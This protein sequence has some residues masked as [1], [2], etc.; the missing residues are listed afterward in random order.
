M[1][2]FC[3]SPGEKATSA[4]KDHYRILLVDDEADILHV[5][6]RKL[7]AMALTLMLLFPLKKR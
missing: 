4:L 1:K 5:L 3:F 7:E 6:K 2:D